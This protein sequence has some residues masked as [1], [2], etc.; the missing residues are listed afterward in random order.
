MKSQYR[1][2]VKPMRKLAKWR[3]RSL[4]GQIDRTF[5]VMQGQLSNFKLGLI[6]D[7]ALRY[8]VEELIEEWNLL[9]WFKLHPEKWCEPSMQA[10][11][12]REP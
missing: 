4:Q 9:K 5:E 6:G 2:K 11:E 8:R 12:R 3:G 7:D 1:T 10:T